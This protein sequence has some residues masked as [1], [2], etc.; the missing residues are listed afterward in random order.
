[1]TKTAKGGGVVH[2]WGGKLA[3]F[4]SYTHLSQDLTTGLLV[5][6]LPF[7]RQDLGLNYLQSG[8]LVS[9]Y[10][11]TS[12]FSQVIGGCVGDRISRQKTMAIG[13]G[14]IG[15]CAVAIGLSSSYYAMLGILIIMGIIAG[16]YHP[17]AVSTL[18]GCFEDARRGKAIALHM[19]G[20]SIGFGIGPLLGSAIAKGLGWHFAYMILSLPALVA[21]P[22]ILTKL[23]LPAQTATTTTTPAQHNS[24]SERSLP[25]LVQI[26]RSMAVVVILSIGVHLI[27]GPCLAFIPLYL[28]DQHHLSTSA[29]A[30]WVSIIRVGGLVGSLFGGWLADKWGRKRA[31]F[32]ALVA[33]GPVLYLLAK[34]PFNAALIAVF[35]LFGFV[36]SMREATVQTYLMENTPSQL[37]ATVFGIYFG[38][39]MEGSSVIQPI[40]GQFMDVIGIAGVFNIIALIGIALSA[41]AVLLYKKA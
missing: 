31:I 36:L 26:F 35:V 28:V 20:G 10:S 6:L 1:M 2:Q 18:T 16:A 13:L 5:A 39:G 11:L 3:I 8:L 17:S 19:L 23:R 7:I 40:A 34:L 29:A 38:F 9:A 37:R 21:V 15:L 32:S 33:T 14:G 25:R 41:G 27:I 22:L 24:K 30:T 12:G 4:F